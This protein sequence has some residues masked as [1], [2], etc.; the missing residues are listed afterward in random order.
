MTDHT[1]LVRAINNRLLMN[2]YQLREFAETEEEI[3]SLDAK[4]ADL[5]ELKDEVLKGVEDAK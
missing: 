2:Y 3:A 4:I 5:L 1:N